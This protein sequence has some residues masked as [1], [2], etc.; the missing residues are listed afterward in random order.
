MSSK[1]HLTSSGFLVNAPVRFAILD[2]PPHD[3]FLFTRVNFFLHNARIPILV[4]RP[5]ELPNVSLM[6]ADP[7]S[8]LFRFWFSIWLFVPYLA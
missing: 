1:D 4:S 2:N 3:N 6:C 7:V 8:F 5:S